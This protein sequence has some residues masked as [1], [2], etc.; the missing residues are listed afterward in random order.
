MFG[1]FVSSIKHIT[2]GT[3]GSDNSVAALRWAVHEAEIHVASVDVVYSWN[4]PPVVDPL[5]VSMLP[6]IDDMTASATR[7]LQRV[8]EKVETKDIAVTSR[9]VQGAPATALLQAAK[10][11]DLLVIGRRGHGG[12]MGLLLGSVAQHVAHHAPCPVVLVPA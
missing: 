5:G 7:L 9:V 1:G 12:F 2:V 6:T 8:M 3:D 4:F 11:T 10:D